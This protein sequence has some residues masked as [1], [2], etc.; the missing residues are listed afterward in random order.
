[1]SVA[2]VDRTHGRA[3]RLLARIVL[4]KPLTAPGVAVATLLACLAL[5]PSLLPRPPAFQGAVCGVVAA[6][7]YGLGGLGTPAMLRG[8]GTPSRAPERSGDPR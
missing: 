5:T 7:G 8:G 4:P 6:L 3:T 1:M 2:A